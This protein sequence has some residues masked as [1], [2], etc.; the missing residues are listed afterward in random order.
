MHENPQTPEERH[1]YFVADFQHLTDQQAENEQD[2]RH[3]SFSM[4]VKADSAESALEKFRQR[5]LMFK[6]S[7][8]F[9]EGRCTIFVSQLIEFDQFPQQ[10]AVI[11]NFK[12]FA[13]DPLMPFIAC[14]VPSAQNNACSIHEWQNNRP[15]TE[16]REDSVFL[17]FK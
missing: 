6:N 5:L 1:M 2:R 13:G 10:D 8:T 17:E 4:I 12:S 16:G 15:V 9:F 7:T 14:A 3:G 11:L